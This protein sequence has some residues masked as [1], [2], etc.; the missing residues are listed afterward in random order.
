MA[1][2]PPQPLSGSSGCPPIQ[3]IL[4][5]AKSL[6]GWEASTLRGA[7]AKPVADTFFKKF[8]REVGVVFID[9]KL[10]NINA[11]LKEPRCIRAKMG[12]VSTKAGIRTNC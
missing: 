6:K 4:S 11:C 2:V 7:I 8:L 5:A 3:R 12:A 10:I 9:V 1:S